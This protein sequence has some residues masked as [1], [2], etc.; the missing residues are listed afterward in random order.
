MD[1]RGSE[2]EAAGERGLL[3]VA[4]SLM[5]LRRSVLC[6]DEVSQLGCLR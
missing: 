4:A 5:M 6:R 1:G 3:K 2:E